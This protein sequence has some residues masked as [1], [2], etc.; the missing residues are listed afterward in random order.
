MVFDNY[1]SH[2]LVFDKIFQTFKVGN[3]LEF[4]PGKYS[5]PFLVNKCQTVTS[6]EQDSLQWYDQVKSLIHSPNWSIFFQQDPQVIFRE[7]DAEGKKFDLVFSDGSEKTRH[8]V[9]NMAMQRN[10]PLVVLHD[11]EKIWYYKWNL[12][13][14]PADYCR[15][16]FRHNEGVKKVTT[17]L[18]NKHADMIEN[19]VIPEH[20]RVLHI[21]TSPNQPVFQMPYELVCELTK[22]QATSKSSA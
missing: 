22:S 2:I 13:D 11:A 6:V 16:D 7:A 20:D 12:L 5:T 17:L 8:L 14:I 4:G 10:V 9:A 18:V 3:V 21:Y 1:S 15:F 19:W